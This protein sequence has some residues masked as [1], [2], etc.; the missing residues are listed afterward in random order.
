[1]TSDIATTPPALQLLDEAASGGPITLA[2]CTASPSSGKVVA[3]VA[4]DPRGHPTTYRFTAAGDL[5]SVTDALG[6]TTM[7]AR[8]ATTNLVESVTDVLNRTTRF[9]YDANGNVLT[10]T[11]P[12]SHVRSF[13]YHT[14]F[15]KVLTATDP[16]N[17]TTTFT[18]DAAGNLLTT[19][20]P[21]GHT[22]TRAYDAVS[23]LIEQTS[24]L[25]F[26]TRLQYDALNRVTSVRDPKNGV[27]RFSYDPN[28]NLLSLTDA[29]SNTT[30]WTY[31]AM[32]RVATRTDPLTRSE[33]FA[34]DLRGNLA[35]HTDR[36]GQVA[37][38]TYDALN[39]RTGATYADATVSYTYDAAGRLTEAVDSAGGTITNTYDLL[40]RLASQAQ[41]YG[42]V[43]YTYDAGGRRTTMSVPGQAQVGYAYDIA[44][45][46]TSITQGANVV[47]FAY[48][49]ASRRTS[50]TLPNGVRTEYD[51]D[52]ANQLSVLTYKLDAA[53]LGELQYAY[54]AAG[55]RV[56]VAGSWARTGLPEAVESTA[57]N[58]NNH[59]LAFGGQALTHD[60]NGNLTHDGVNMYVWDARNRLVGITGRTPSSFAYDGLGRRR[61]KTITGAATGFL[62]DGVNPVKEIA[63][64]GGA[65]LLT[66][67]GID[68]Y[69]TR[70]SS[71]GTMNFLTDTLGSTIALAG[72]AGSIHS[73]HTYEPFGRDA[74]AALDNPFQYTGRENDGTGLYYYRARY[75][76]P[77]LQRF[78]SEDPLGIAA[79]GGVNRY[80]YALNS[81]MRFVDPLGTDVYVA[82]Y[83]ALNGANHIG[84]GVNSAN[85]YGFYSR[86]STP[87][88]PGEVVLDSLRHPE[89]PIDIIRITTSASDDAAVLDFIT[90][91]RNDPGTYNVGGRMFGRNCA[92]FVDEALKR[93]HIQGGAEF[94]VAWPNEVMGAVNR[95]F[96]PMPDVY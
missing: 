68:E 41:P 37:T 53:T 9:T 4:V 58:A 39:R 49:A 56:S 21:L 91:V 7:Y 63:A 48:D 45:R 51:Y 5:E 88:G 76:H 73:E 24:P 66:G 50:L 57:Y 92:S 82:L 28:G 6:H 34:Y 87:L 32:D 3:T 8:N 62:Y 70:T 60:L 17:H 40:D 80:V 65:E 11:D 2:P 71:Q 26:T 10:L 27:T 33:S 84:I 59:Q 55:Q 13:T 96:T 18:Y 35:S 83:R 72:A 54:D 75:Y 12:A 43:T 64:V 86:H 47:Q 52:P 46:L 14:T 90:S 31:D 93:A 19:A 78:I 25:G 79:R 22:T 44:N 30:S 95:Q 85:T 20:D 23:R 1:V 74:T 38:F 36:K 15:N 61:D 29:R 81:P 42:T 89:G 69:L 77:R 67:V 94:P 16:L